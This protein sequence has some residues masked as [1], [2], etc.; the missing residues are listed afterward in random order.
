MPLQPLLL[1][2]E[3]NATNEAILGNIEETLKTQYTPLVTDHGF[4][5][6]ISVVGAGPSLARTYQDLTGDV[7]ACN[8]AHD[9]LLLKGIT[10]KYAMFWDA[11]PILADLFTPVEGVTYLVASRCH[12]KVFLKLKG[13]KVIVWHTLGDV[14]LEKLLAKYGKKEPMVAGG[15]SGVTRGLFLAGA[16][17]YTKEIHLF[18]VDGCYEGEKSHVNGGVD[19]GR[20]QIVVRGKWFVV[21][22][23]MAM[24]GEHFK[25]L[26]PVLQQ[27]KLRLIVHGTGLIP[28]LA[29]FMG[30]ETPDM[31]VGILEQMRRNIHS[32]LEL[33]ATL[34]E[35]QLLGG[36][37]AGV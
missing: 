36:L 17:G 16:M 4:D 3:C 11:N 21:S 7:M 15:S 13:H 24:Q 22:P 9:Y 25:M 33:Y 35:P 34:R 26:L 18:G 5:T 37:H 6:P 8:S 20:M 14:C 1:K 28:Y 29:T 32:A 31:K 12:R 23:W 10:P 19:S 2:G 27:F 30:C